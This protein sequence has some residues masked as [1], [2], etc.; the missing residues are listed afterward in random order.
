MRRRNVM[1]TKCL[2]KRSV[3]AQFLGIVEVD[4]ETLV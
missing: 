1:V 3:G 2:Y 4:R